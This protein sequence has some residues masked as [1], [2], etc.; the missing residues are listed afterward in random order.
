MEVHDGLGYPAKY[1]KLKQNVTE[2]NS[3]LILVDL[4]YLWI[5]FVNLPTH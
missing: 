3:D 4:H 2:D 5:L 1:Y